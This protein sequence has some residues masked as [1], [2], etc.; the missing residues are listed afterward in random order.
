MLKGICRGCQKSFQ[1]EEPA[2]VIHRFQLYCVGCPHCKTFHGVQ[3][4]AIVLYIEANPVPE[5]VMY[6]VWRIEDGKHIECLSGEGVTLQFASDNVQSGNEMAKT[7]PF[8]N[9]QTYYMKPVLDGLA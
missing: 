4:S 9:I 3:D 5:E 8:S 2:N 6:T 1:W 7:K